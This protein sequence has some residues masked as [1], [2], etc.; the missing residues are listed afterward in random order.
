MSRQRAAVAV[1]A[2]L[3]L[4]A[5]L[6]S[7]LQ[8]GQGAL[9]RWSDGGNGN[10]GAT[11]SLSAVLSTPLPTPLPVWQPSCSFEPL[12]ALLSATLSR[13]MYAG[14]G[15]CGDCTGECGG[16]PTELQVK[17]RHRHCGVVGG[18]PTARGGPAELERV[19]VPVRARRCVLAASAACACAHV[20]RRGALGA[21]VRGR[22]DVEPV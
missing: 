10:D 15:G 21:V 4:A 2:A 14:V 6:L 12:R 22:P 3:V 16:C 17:G 18:A 7:L 8:S 13:G 1:I 9:A 20:P 11:M 19:R 5:F